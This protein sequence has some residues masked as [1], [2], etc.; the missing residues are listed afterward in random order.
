MTRRWWLAVS[1]A[2]GAVPCLEGQTI[3]PR[4]GPVG[5]T[6][7][8][9]TAAVR[10]TAR[11]TLFLASR[12]TS[13][14]ARL[15]P[16]LRAIAASFV[17]PDGVTTRL[18]PGT[19]FPDP[20]SSGQVGPFRA[21]SVGPF[22][23][24]LWVDLEVGR[25]QRS[26]W[27]LA[28]GSVQLQAAVLEAVHRADSGQ[29]FAALAPAKGRRQATVHLAL[30]TATESEPVGG[31]SILRLRIPTIRVER[32]VEVIHIPTPAYPAEARKERR[33]G[34]VHLQYVVT[35]EG[36]ASRASMRVVEA[37]DSAFAA[38]AREAIVAGRFQPAR[39]RGCPV[40][41]LVQQRI[42]YRF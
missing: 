25:L 19:Y 28:P 16:T 15:E 36:R 33:R 4:L 24:E 32:T 12:E 35:E 2:V 20:D 8:F 29:A 40:Q 9:D 3:Q 17:A 14:S 38:A 41:M 13:D 31:V 5:S 42:S 21:R 22:T 37:D 11:Y 6:C 39:V 30:R 34:G 7:T 26:R 10:D 18:W 1:L 23:G 27:Y